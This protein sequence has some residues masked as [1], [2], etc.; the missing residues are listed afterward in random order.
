MRRK[1]RLMLKR[2]ETGTRV[3]MW[4]NADLKKRELEREARVVRESEPDSA[5]AASATDSVSNSQEAP[6]IQQSA[7]A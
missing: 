3:K 6:R 2:G 4:K 5:D 1:V 7:A